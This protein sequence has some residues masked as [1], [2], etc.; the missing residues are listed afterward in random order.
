MAKNIKEINLILTNLGVS[1]QLSQPL[2]LF[3]KP[4]NQDEHF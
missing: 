4:I 2:F 1:L 3:N